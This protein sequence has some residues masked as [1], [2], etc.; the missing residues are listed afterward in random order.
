VIRCPAYTE[1][2]ALLVV[3]VFAQVSSRKTRRLA[4]MHDWIAHQR[5]R[6]RATSG[7]PCSWGRASFFKGN[8][9]RPQEPPPRVA[10]HHHTA[11]RLKNRQQRMQR[12]VLLAGM[13]SQQPL[14]F[15]FQYP[16]P[17]AADLARRKVTRRAPALCPLAPVLALTSRCRAAARPTS[18]GPARGKNGPANLP[19][20][21]ASMPASF[22][23]NMQRKTAPWE[24]LRFRLARKDS[25]CVV[26]GPIDGCGNRPRVSRRASD[27]GIAA[28]DHVQAASNE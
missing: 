12:D 20:K 1:Y 18:F 14:A 26:P 21:G 8:P 19:D 9:V 5:P 13:T 27:G 16:R 7:R 24:F 25:S 6:L 23:A 2:Q 10:A 22:P 28:I 4:S 15:D 17:V 11:F 3:L